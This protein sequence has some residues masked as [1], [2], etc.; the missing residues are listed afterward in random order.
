MHRWAVLISLTMFACGDGP[1]TASQPPFAGHWAG[2]YIVRQC[3]FAGWPSCDVAPERVSQVYPFDL[4]MAQSGSSV[5]GSLQIV[6][7]P[8]MTV[9]VTGDTSSSMLVL[10]GTIVNPVMNRVSTDSIRIT[11]WS[12]TRD[13]RDNLQ[14]TFSFRWDTLWGPASMPARS[15]IWTLDYQAELL[16]VAR[17]P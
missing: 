1:T 4:V 13:S 10:S 12:T 6:A 11:S 17:Q 7:S 16:N 5:S 9:P 15:G 2:S 3:A 8:V 14:G